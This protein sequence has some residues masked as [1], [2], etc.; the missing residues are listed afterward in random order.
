MHADEYACVCVHICACMCIFLPGSGRGMTPILAVPAQ[1]PAAQM[2]V[3]KKAR[4]RA[5]LKERFSQLFSNLQQNAGIF[6]GA[7]TSIF[8]LEHTCCCCILQKQTARVFKQAH[9][10]S[11]MY[12]NKRTGI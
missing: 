7:N 9:S 1:F 4:A 2:C 10:S 11:S 12:E 6:T 3:R 8:S 5:T